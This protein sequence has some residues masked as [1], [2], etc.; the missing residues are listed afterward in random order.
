MTF[1]IIVLLLLPIFWVRLF[2]AFILLI[3]H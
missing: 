2:P 1:P 3:V